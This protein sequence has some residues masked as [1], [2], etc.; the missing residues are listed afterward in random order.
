MTFISNVIIFWKNKEV[1][2]L[3][4]WYM[5]YDIDF[6]NIYKFYNPFSAGTRMQ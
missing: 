1:Y 2:D 6:I 4:N 3:Y 5:T